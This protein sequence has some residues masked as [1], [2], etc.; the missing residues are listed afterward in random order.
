MA[1]KILFCA[2]VDYHFELFH[3]PYMKWFKDQGW[4]VDVAALGEIKL[5]YTDNKYNIPI[6]RSPFNKKNLQAYKKL[7]NIIDEGDYT[8]I[9]CHTP[10]GGGL[11][12]LAA[13]GARE[14]GT[15]VI[16]TAHGFH[17]CKGAPLI[18][19]LVYYPIEKFLSRITDTLITIN[20]EDYRLAVKHKFKAGNIKQVH[21]VGVNTDHFKPLDVNQKNEM[22]KSFGYQPN[23]FLLFYAAEFNN[24]KNQKFL[25]QSLALIKND[26]PGARLV[27]AGEGALLEN[28]RELAIALGIG[29]MVDFLGYQKNI[30]QLVSI[31]D[32]AVAS[33]LREGLPVNIMEAMSCGL[34]IVAVNNRG[35]RELVQNNK[36]GWL[37]EHDDKK[38]FSNKIKMLESVPDLKVK[39]GKNGRE[40]ILKTY[41]SSKVLSEISKIYS[42]YMIEEEE[43]EWSVH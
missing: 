39:L 14:R 13:K 21:G 40:M 18:N 8:I 20:K 32:V 19:W 37:V 29:H 24:N 17:F 27:L 22:K 26:V 5:L 28:C 6:Q 23:D 12:R 2:T 7:K 11:T 41:S 3:L 31:C 30:Q 16:Y 42:V 34:P 25:L 43:P 10:I 4:Q 35:H 9:H 36:N 38:R 15:K 1:K 33:S